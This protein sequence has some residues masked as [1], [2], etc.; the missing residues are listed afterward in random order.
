MD[1]TSAL[2]TSSQGTKREADALFVGQLAAKKP[3]ESKYIIPSAEELFEAVSTLPV[4]H[5][6]GSQPPSKSRY[7]PVI[8]EGLIVDVI[9]GA[10]HKVIPDRPYT[11]SEADT[12]PASIA[13]L[14]VKA[15]V[16]GDSENRYMGS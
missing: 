2:S 1:N 16:H 8:D 9:K 14:I 7:S 11:S 5:I 12:W 15:L 13:D 10:V 3:R 6:S 4:P